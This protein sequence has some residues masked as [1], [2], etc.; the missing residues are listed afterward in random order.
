MAEPYESAIRLYRTGRFDIA[1]SLFELG[2]SEGCVD[3]WYGLSLVHASASRLRESADAVRRALALRD[4]FGAAWRMLGMLALREGR[5]SAMSSSFERALACSATPQAE[6][7]RD[8]ASAFAH[9]GDETSALSGAGSRIEVPLLDSEGF[10]VEASVNERE[11][12]RF[13]FDTGTAPFCVLDVRAASELG[14]AVSGERSTTSMAG[15]RRSVGRGLLTSLRVGSVR[16]ERVPVAVIDLAG[17]ATRERVTGILSPELFRGRSL[18]VDHAART[19]IFADDAEASEERDAWACTE[20]RCVGGLFLARVSVGREDVWMVVDTGC[21]VGRIDPQ[22]AFA[23]GSI[24]R[25]VR[26]GGE[27]W[28]AFEPEVELRWAHW[29]L[30]GVVPRSLH[31]ETTL[32][33]SV[34][35]AG[36]LGRELF[37]QHRVK[38]D[39]RSRTA[40]LRRHAPAGA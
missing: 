36:L 15:T 23:A 10:V 8:C 31:L 24:A 29:T 34:E 21:R 37:R 11:P 30:R 7:M 1:A 9:A 22:V 13:F 32:P 26:I 20:L 33:E 12:A 14:V 38:L 2:A 5:L 28:V 25:S 18:E 16:A 3:C 40:Q 6:F 19:L 4:D 35:L 39:P 17:P 27:S